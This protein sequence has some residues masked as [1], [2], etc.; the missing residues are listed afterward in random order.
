LVKY[1][2]AAVLS[3]RTVALYYR[4]FILY[5]ICWESGCTF[6]ETQAAVLFNGGGDPAAALAG[7]G[8][9]LVGSCRIVALCYCSSTSYKIR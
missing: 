4:S 8:E 1:P 2:Q 5:Q 9:A 7:L 6:S 3:G